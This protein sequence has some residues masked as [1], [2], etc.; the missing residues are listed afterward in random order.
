MLPTCSKLALKNL[1]GI[2]DF[3][4]LLKNRFVYWI[5]ANEMSK[6]KRCLNCGF[7][8][9]S[10]QEK[11]IMSKLPSSASDIAAQAGL[12]RRH[13]SQVLRRLEKA[14][15]VKRLPKVGTS[16]LIFAKVNTTE[17]VEL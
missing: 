3:V 9:Y 2:T 12:S 6:M 15:R 14:K 17:G 4:C 16:G 8:S 5:H 1:I 13:V 7:T 11:L 10:P